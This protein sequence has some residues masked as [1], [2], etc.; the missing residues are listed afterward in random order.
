MGRRINGQRSE[1]MGP[2]QDGRRYKIKRLQSANSDEERNF[3][4]VSR[5]SQHESSKAICETSRRFLQLPRFGMDRY[6]T[7]RL[8]IK[9][10]DAA[11]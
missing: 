8:A 6:A 1:R 2:T 9:T 10:A 11:G 4:T 3:G 5:R 7:R